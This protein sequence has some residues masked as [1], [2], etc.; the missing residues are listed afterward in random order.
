VVVK[1]RNTASA[2]PTGVAAALA[3]SSSATVQ[4]RG[5]DAPRCA[6]VALPTVV[7]HDGRTFKA[8]K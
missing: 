3:T 5:S 2:L 8:K 4:I 7:K 6:S 1:G